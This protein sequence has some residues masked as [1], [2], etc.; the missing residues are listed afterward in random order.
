MGAANNPATGGVDFDKDFAGARDWP[1]HALELH[2]FGWAELMHAPSHHRRV[3][4]V[5]CL[6]MG[7][8][9]CR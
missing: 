8:A 2:R 6:I 5:P 1:R 7:A 3:D 4:L 9:V